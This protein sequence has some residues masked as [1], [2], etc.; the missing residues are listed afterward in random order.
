VKIT[1]PEKVLFP[2]DGVT[3]RDLVDYYRRVAAWILPHLRARP[4]SLERY[5]DGIQEARIIQKS[6]SAYYPG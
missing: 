5:P 6:V 4:L 3:K 1:R 2:D